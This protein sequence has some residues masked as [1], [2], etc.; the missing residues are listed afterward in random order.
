MSKL[1]SLNLNQ[2]F[3]SNIEIIILFILTSVLA[4]AFVFKGFVTGDMIRY[5]L[6]MRGVIENGLTNTGK[7][8]D[9]EIGFGYYVILYSLYSLF[10]NHI[11]LS[12]LM[13]YLSAKA[14]LFLICNLF[15][16]FKT[17]SSDKLLSL[18]ACI[19]VMLSA[20]IWFI[21]HYG[22]PN[23]LSL[24]FLFSSINLFILIAS[25]P[26]HKY[27]V[28][29]WILFF[30][31]SII[32]LS[33]RLDTILSYASLF[34]LLYYKQ[35]FNLKSLYKTVI[36][37]IVIVLLTFLLRY[38]FI[39]YFLSPGGGTVVYHLLHRIEPSILIKNIFVNLAFWSISANVIFS[40]VAII[41]F[42]DPRISSRLKV[43][44]ISMIIPWFIFLPFRA[45]DT[46][47]ILVPTFPIIIYLATHYT[48]FLFRK[49]K[50]ASLTFLLVLSQLVSVFLYLP[51]TKSFNFKKSVDGR[52]LGTLPLGFLPKDNFVRQ[53]YINTQS[54]I[55]DKISVAKDKDVLIIGESG[56]SLMYY[57]WSLYN[58]RK[59]AS[60]DE[61]VLNEVFIALYKTESNT[62]YFLELNQN[63][64][65]SDPLQRTF[66]YFKDKKV[67]THVVPY[68]TE[69]P[70]DI[71]NLFIDENDSIQL[72]EREVA[73]MQTR[74]KY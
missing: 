35:L 17:L 67:D 47:R 3:R 37:L 58:S 18:F 43:L 70:V 23:I 64:Q 8:F 26:A 63:R 72:L 1:K 52:F 25:K 4:F 12:T 62:F 19:G 56:N 59:I 20:G 60:Y 10:G 24:T 5:S 51:I 14:L 7:G 45:M 28:A 22:N 69:Y 38:L 27:P 34:G 39:G 50:L 11:T 9:S 55:A 6:G 46:G 21:S 36:A 73:V 57:V 49:Y 13:N 32:T 44:F 29:L 54:Q 16:F 42:L 31:L 30:I 71:E 68:W 2:Y 40:A 61:I 15:Y 33:I 65:L 66:E 41:G 74:N 53:K 48:V